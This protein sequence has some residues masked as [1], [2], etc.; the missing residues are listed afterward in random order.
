L[1]KPVE[2]WRLDIKPD[3]PLSIR[4]VVSRAVAVNLSENDD[5]LADVTKDSDLVN[6]QTLKTYPSKKLSR[7]IGPK[8]IFMVF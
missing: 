1:D 5:V 8:M 6:V 3:N 4:Y 7:I 2:T